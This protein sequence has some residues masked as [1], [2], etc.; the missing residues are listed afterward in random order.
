[1]EALSASAWDFGSAA[2]LLNRAG[3]GGTPEEIEALR[4]LGLE[5]AV[6]R[7]LRYRAVE[8]TIEPPSWAKPD[9]DRAERL[10]K[11]RTA[12][13]EARAA[14]RR[15]EQSRQREQTLDLRRWWVGRMAATRRPLEERMVLFWHGHFATSIQKVRDAWLMY[16]QLETFRAHATGHWPTLLMAV[17]RD[18]AMLVW[19]DQARSRRDHPNEN[20]AREVMELFAL[21]EGNYTEA[22][23]LEAARALTGLGFDPVNQEPVWRPRQHD[24]GLKTVLGHRARLE[25]EGVIRL[26]AEHPQSARFLARKLWAFFAGVPATAGQTEALARSFVEGRR[27]VSAL[28]RTLFLSRDF[29]AAEVRRVQIKSPTQWLVMALRHLDRPVPRAEMVTQV[30]RE[31]GQELLAPPN[32]KGW[33]EG[34]AW[35]NTG[36][37]TR[38][39]QYASLL[40]GGL[41]AVPGLVGGERGAKLGERLARR[42]GRGFGP[43]LGRVDVER[44]FG[45]EDRAD[46]SRI[47][48]ALER[49]FLQARLRPRLAEEVRAALGDDRAPDPRAIARAVRVVMESTDYQLT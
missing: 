43:A 39:R 21:G 44:L 5:A 29:Y 45:A 42:R 6:D 46:R 9:P 14:L 40:V 36:T 28:L 10:R 25:P 47:E 13:A 30:M 37:L 2:H 24:P 32:V 12:T 48:T 1:M 49:R 22:D 3:F 33:D 23:V 31:L 27:E 18:P 11:A 19:L 16:R 26:I 8:E 38:R 4:A 20:Y 35:I 15:E 34:V 41:E 7:L 17:T